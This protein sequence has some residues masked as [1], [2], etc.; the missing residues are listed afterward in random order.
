MN[1]LIRK[2]PRPLG[3]CA[4]C[5]RGVGLHEL[6]EDDLLFVG[7]HADAG[8]GDLDPQRHI[9]VGQLLQ[10]QTQEDLAFPRSSLI[11]SPRQRTQTVPPSRWRYRTIWSYGWLGP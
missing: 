2:T 11:A 7:R 1:V 6:F 10:A 4:A 8:V 9:L 5:G 3:C